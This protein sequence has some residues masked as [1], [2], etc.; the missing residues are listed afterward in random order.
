MFNFIKKI[1]RNRKRLRNKNKEKSKRKLIINSIKNNSIAQ[2]FSTIYNTENYLSNLCEL[3]GT[4][5][6]YVKFEKDT[7]YGWKPHSYSIFYSS[8]FSHCKESIKLVFE[9]GIGSNY[10]DV[11]SNMSPNGKPGASLRVWKDYFTNAEIFGA[12]IDKRILFQ[13]ERIKTFEVNQLDSSSIKEM[14]SKINYNNFDLIVDDGL[15]THD[16]AV[17]FFL[18][19]FEKL[20]KDGIY[21]IEDVDLRDLNDLKNSLNKFNPEVVIL[22]NNYFDQYPI[23]NNNLIVIRKT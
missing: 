16:A 7:P 20:K 3:Y 2:N 9:C 21:I 22:T 13:E 11:E 8:L 10:L 23:N 17:T 19:S 5:K 14:W 6:G 18:N 15:H 4:D 12:D 1:N